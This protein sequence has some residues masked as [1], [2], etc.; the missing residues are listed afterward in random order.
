[1]L[2]ESLYRFSRITQSEIGKMVGGIDYSAV[3]QAR[4]RL[5]Q[6]LTKDKALRQRFETLNKELIDLSRLKI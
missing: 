6:R 5:R 1:M 2:M 3:S 4:S